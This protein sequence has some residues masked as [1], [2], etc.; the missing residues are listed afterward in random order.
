MFNFYALFHSFSH[1][2]FVMKTGMQL[3]IYLGCNSYIMYTV[4]LHA[5]ISIYIF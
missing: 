1:Y 4:T 5:V 3:Y 2:S